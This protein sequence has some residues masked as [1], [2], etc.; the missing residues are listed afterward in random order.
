MQKSDE[1]TAFSPCRSSW[2][3]G[4]CHID[5]LIHDGLRL[6]DLLISSNGVFNAKGKADIIQ[7]LQQTFAAE[8][9][10]LKGEL[11]VAS[12]GDNLIF[13]VNRDLI[14]GSAF[15]AAKKFV[16]LLFRKRHRQHSVLEAIIAK[17]IRK[18]RSDQRADAVIQKRPRRVFAA[19]AAAEIG[20]RQQ[21]AGSVI[22]RLV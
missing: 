5:R 1:G 8:G 6:M 11:Q 3:A 21:D 14:A 19:G 20:A 18:T 15:R 13:Q 22:A 10:N 7:A 12:V 4:S 16:H 9:V 2:P 17:N